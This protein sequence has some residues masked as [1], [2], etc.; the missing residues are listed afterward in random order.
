MKEKKLCMRINDV[1]DNLVRV[2][3]EITLKLHTTCMIGIS[4]VKCILIVRLQNDYLFIHTGQ[5]QPL[6]VFKFLH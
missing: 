2:I 3:S 5:I 1:V 6:F 4:K